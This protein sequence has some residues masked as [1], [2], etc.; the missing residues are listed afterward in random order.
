MS[1]RENVN[2][3]AAN[4]ANEVDHGECFYSKKDLDNLLANLDKLKELSIAYYNENRVRDVKVFMLN[5]ADAVAA[6]SLE[7]AKA[8]YLKNVIMDVGVA[9]MDYEAHE[10]ELTYAVWQDDKKTKKEV[11]SDLILEFWQGVP[12]IIFSTEG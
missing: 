8:W 12:F 5:E 1:L 9:F 11:L 3:Q 4:I 7:D 6:E 2:N 10:V